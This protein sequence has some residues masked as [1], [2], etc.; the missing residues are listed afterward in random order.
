MSNLAL[1]NLLGCGYALAMS[2]GFM[3]SV[4]TVSVSA[5]DMDDDAYPKASD[6]ATMV[7]VLRSNKERTHFFVDDKELGVGK[8]LVVK[9][10][11]QGHT[12]AA[13]PEN[14]E[15]AKEEFVQ[16][17]YSPDVPLSFTF[18]KDDC[19]PT[20]VAANDG[21]GSLN[22]LSFGNVSGP[23]IINNGS[24]SVSGNNNTDSHNT[25]DS[26]NS[27]VT[28][29]SPRQRTSAPSANA[30]KTPTSSNSKSSASGANR[31]AAFKEIT[32][33]VQTVCKST[34]DSGH[35]QSTGL[36]GEIKAEFSG[37]LKSLANLG[38]VGKAEHQNSDYKG[39]LQQ[40]LA[41][42]LSKDADC[43]S[44]LSKM[45]IDKLIK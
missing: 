34:E 3:L 19:E 23:I 40:D 25:T 12:I 14:C 7:Y 26:H 6:D 17:P 2:I 36:T 16:P 28:Q 15:A 37:L 42:I 9:L 1:K 22:G 18:L 43:R 45:L 27:N 33:F 38:V 35:T 24:G 30:R 5:A 29:A 41:S 31:Q 20:A 32:I 13:E 11:N 10:N 21:Q 39:V 8:K 4:Y 44:D